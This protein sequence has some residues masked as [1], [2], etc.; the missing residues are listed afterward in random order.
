MKFQP[1]LRHALMDEKVLYERSPLEE[2]QRWLSQAEEDLK[3]VKDLAD[4]GGYYLAAFQ[5]RFIPKRLPKR[6]PRWQ[7]KS[8]HRFD[9]SWTASPAK[10]AESAR[11][12]SHSQSFRISSVRYFERKS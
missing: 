7:K 4:R 3:W 6:P 8:F 11:T 9:P 2:G 1:F 10:P 5:R 12:R